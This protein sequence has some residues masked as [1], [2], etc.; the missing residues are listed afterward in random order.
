MSA[1][2]IFESPK[3]AIQKQL[4]LL[5]NSAHLM[6]DSAVK[7]IHEKWRVF[8]A[9]MDQIATPSKMLICPSALRPQIN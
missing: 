9:G 6:L 8:P 5:C 4:F 2:L 1:S 7:H 3:K